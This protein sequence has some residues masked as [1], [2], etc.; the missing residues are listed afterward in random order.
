MP[1][2]VFKPAR[3]SAEGRGIPTLRVLSGGRLVLNAAAL[4]MIGDVRFV[5]L[6]W[7]AGTKRIGIKSTSATDPSAFKVTRAPSQAIITSAA[8]V[9]ENKLSHSLKMR[10]GWDGRMWIASTTTPDE[11]LRDKE[12]TGSP[13]PI[14]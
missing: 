6:L 2:E 12:G 3:S 1:F 11:P 5:Q 14:G 9:T 4:R 8:F 13:E 7:D 10:L